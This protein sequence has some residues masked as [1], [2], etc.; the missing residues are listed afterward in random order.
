MA[1][2]AASYVHRRLRA[3]LRGRFSESPHARQR[4]GLRI[5]LVDVQILKRMD[6]ATQSL[7]TIRKRIEH[8]D[9]LLNQ[10][11][12][13]IVSSQAFLLTGY[14]VLLNAPLELRN[15]EFVHAHALLMKLIPLTS[16]C[17]TVLLWFGILAG[18]LAMRDLRACAETH[19]GYESSHRSE[20]RR[21]GKEC[22]SRWSPYH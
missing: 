15:K 20:E 9:N 1:I 3:L 22:R 6:D 13:W 17:V 12:S 10:R 16:I 21:V 11:L 5:R 19:P 8:E 7:E 4:G 18:I 14:A 2:A